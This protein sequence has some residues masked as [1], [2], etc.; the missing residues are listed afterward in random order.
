MIIILDTVCF[1]HL[2]MIELTGTNAFFLEERIHGEPDWLFRKINSPPTTFDKYARSLREKETI[3]SLFHP[4]I[5]WHKY[6]L[7]NIGNIYSG[8]YFL[9][10]NAS[11]IKR[12]NQ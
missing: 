6:S 9:D 4:I 10:A 8:L 11:A 3:S 12:E 1:P 2:I 7:S 5:V